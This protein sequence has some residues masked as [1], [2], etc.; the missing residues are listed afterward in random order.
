[1]EI[2]NV[3]ATNLIKVLT[4]LDLT[5]NGA[6]SRW[7]IPQKTLESV[8]KCTRVPSLETAERIAKKTGFELWQLLSPNFDPSNP[9][10]IVPLTP[11]EQQFYEDFKE[12][13][14]KSKLGQK[15]AAL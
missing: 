11:E 9:P 6:A 7:R 2:S 15:Q 8:V 14:N 12:L 10:M 4:H 3:F 1:M 5:P 13:I